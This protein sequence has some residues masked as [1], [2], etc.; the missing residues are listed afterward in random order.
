[1]GNTE[2]ENLNINSPEITNISESDNN[3][4]NTPISFFNMK[5]I[6][7]KITWNEGG[8]KVLLTGD[9]VEWNTYFVLS[10]DEISN[11]FFNYPYTSTK[12]NSI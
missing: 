8:N 10:K 2:S 11:S 12:T 1:M 5:T 9:F 6:Q 4:N 3:N 7:Y